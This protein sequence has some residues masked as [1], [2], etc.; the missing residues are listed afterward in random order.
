MIKLI[1]DIILIL[2]YKLLFPICLLFGA[3]LILGIFTFLNYLIK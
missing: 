2:F 1:K 3:F